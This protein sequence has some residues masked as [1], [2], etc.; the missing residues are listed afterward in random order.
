MRVLVTGGGGY[1][2]SWVVGELLDRGHEVRV[3][4]RFCFGEESLGDIAVSPQC[5]VVRGDIRRL[6]ECPDLLD[7]VEGV[8]HL[9]ALSNDMSCDLDA[10]MAMDVNVE[11]TRELVAQAV[12]HGVRRFVFRSSCSV[13]GK[14]VFEL[15]DEKSPTNPVSTFGRTKLEAEGAVMALA[16]DAFEAVV[17][18]AATLFGSSSRMRFDL[19]LNQMVAT[20][21]RQ[22][23]IDVMGG[24]NQWRPFVHVRDA[25]RAFADMVEA[26]AARVSGEVFNVGSA[27]MN[28]RIVDLAEYVAAKLGGVPVEGVK[29]DDD[30]RSYSVEF[31]KIREGLGF[32][33]VYTL[34]DGIEEV[35]GVVEGMEADPFSEPYINVERMRTL[36]DTPVDEGGEP[37]AP[38]FIA[39]AKPNLGPEEESAVVE[40]LRSGWLTTGA[41][42][43]AFERQFSEL[44]GAAHTVA[45]NSCTAALHLCLAEL[46][47][48]PGDEV[49]TSPLTW[50]STGNTIMSLGAKVVFADVNPGTLNIDPALIEDAITDR[51][52]AL[53]PVHLGGQPCEL[54]TIY[55][56]ARRR[57][58]GVV[59]DAA[60]ALGASYKGTPV[61]GYGDLSCF[62][63]YA[64]KNITTIEGGTIT[65]EDEDRAAR[66]RLLASNGMSSIAWQRYGRSAEARPPEVVVPGF[67]YRMGDVSAAI[68]L[69][70]LKKFDAFKA[71]RHRIARLYFSVLEDIE[72]I[73]LPE[74]I[75][76]VEHAWHLMIVRFDSAKLKKSRDEL[77]QA[78][79]R[80]NVATGI[81]FLGLHLHEYYRET[82]GMN[83]DDLPH[84]TKASHEILSLPLHPA[85][86]DKNVHDVVRALKKVLA[87]AR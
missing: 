20:G 27:A 60:H 2:G 58:I 3:F 39:L 80:E 51:T 68:G 21:V 46:G 9:A 28:H 16:S 24:G 66:L 12:T 84:A 59:E 74:I 6:Q 63:F 10:E 67:K 30:L 11:S 31:E 5:E 85:M 61:G 37:I 45:V 36:L 29:G 18:R 53:M 57:G 8:V 22:G 17:G 19:A 41:K 86:S 13:Y 7:G 72:E 77:A 64:I 15:L 35:R 87:H 56:I 42:V 26:P 50:A 47:V 69:E 44:V 38:R 75:E 65:L 4:D 49:I 78:L 52:K 79:R 25:A 43:Q 82:L 33:A 1:L 48:G 55:E 23:R 32:E 54:E 40:T 62:S 71:A 76:G 14:G 34:D 70:Q 73:S 83:P 81:H